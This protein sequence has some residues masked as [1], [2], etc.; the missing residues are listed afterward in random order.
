[1]RAL[2]K[3]GSGHVGLD[4]FM[5][6]WNLGLSVAALSDTAEVARLHQR[7]ADGAAQLDAVSRQAPAPE[8]IEKTFHAHDRDASGGLGVRELGASLRELGLHTEGSA[9]RVL[10]K[11][12]GGGDGLLSLA[13]FI[14]LVRTRAR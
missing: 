13:E 12:D 7:A 6:W 5:W 3:D 9:A 14:R 1:M 2:D 10:R 4:E 11:Y 8:E